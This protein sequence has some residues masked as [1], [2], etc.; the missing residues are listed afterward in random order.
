[1]NAFKAGD[2][3][4]FSSKWLKSTQAHELGRDRGTVLSVEQIGHLTLC[5]V[6][7]PDR[8]SRVL[9]KNLVHCSRMYLEAA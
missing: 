2:S 7:W 8:V 1:M 5:S 3:V 6:Q 9:S 4:A